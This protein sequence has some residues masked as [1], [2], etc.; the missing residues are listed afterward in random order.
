[1]ATYAVGDI[2]GRH[3]DFLRL[4]DRIGFSPGNDSL[5]LLG[6]LV[7]RGPDS[8]AV[9]R[10]A[11]THPGSVR[12]ILGNH[13]LYLI[14]VLDN[15]VQP[16]KRDTFSDI[17][18]AADRDRILEWLC[19]QPLAVHDPD[20]NILAV[21]A[22]VHPHWTLDE[23]M[24]YAKEVERV[25]ASGQR[26]EFLRQML[27]NKPRRWSESLTG[28]ERTRFLVNVFTRMRYIK[29]NGKLD[30]KEMRTRGEQ[31]RNLTPWFEFPG[32]V[33]IRPT[34]VFGHWSSLGVYQ[35]PGILAMDSGCCWGRCLSAAR[36]DGEA[37]AITQVSCKK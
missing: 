25:L 34:I 26:Q 8:L 30:F 18:E 12:I 35:Q 17:I 1:M 20:L 33:R 24:T 37:F 32:R 31:D 9:V 7:N 23:T 10:F 2:Q 19:R 4:L 28:W 3:N 13:D 6:D 15:T 29:H 22:G 5:I 16:R 11:M 14:G 21:H 36:L 27:G